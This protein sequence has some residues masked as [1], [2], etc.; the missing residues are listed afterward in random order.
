MNVVLV[1]PHFPPDHIGGVEQYS[2]RLAEDLRRHGDAPH[3]VC[4]E[5]I[6]EGASVSSQVDGTYGYPVHRVYVGRELLD[7]PVS[8]VYDVPGVESII[9]GVLDS[10]RADV[11]H[12]HS[13]Y[14][15]G[16]S[17][18][19]A[20]RRLEVPT[21]VTLHDFWF[22]CS[23]ITIIHPVGM[24]CPGPESAVKCA[25][26]LG[27]LRRRYRLPERLTGRR[28]GRLIEGLARAP[29]LRDVVSRLDVV[30]AVR[31]RQTRLLELLSQADVILSPSRFVRDR[32]AEAGLEPARVLLSRYG[33]EPRQS[34]QAGRADDAPLRIGYLGQLAPHKGVHVLIDAVRRL[35]GSPLTLHVHG[36][37]RPH[38]AYVERL[39]KAALGDSRI[40]FEG[41][42]PH[43]RVYDIL[44][45]LDV[46]VVPSVW[47]ENSPFV[48]QEAQSAH[49]PV[50][51]S[52]L[53]G[54]Q[55]LVADERDGL[56]FAAGDAHDLSRQLQRVVRTP[57]LLRQLR[58]DGSSVRQAD[59]ELRELRGHYARV[60]SARHKGRDAQ[61]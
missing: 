48:I 4:L 47:Y 21:V 5:A 19:A 14:L 58:P 17:A 40:H 30:E 34:N 8:S 35:Q 29:V 23:L 42:Y 33:I 57:G 3:V 11:V 49:V 37:P 32:I 50:L 59:D 41:P 10:S 1:T 7:A 6:H 61:T 9:A 56:L 25:W 60:A 31:M 18:L 27:T 28:A 13:G 43:D 46:I 26:C 53:G 45:G 51:A 38:P 20:A 55:E 39:H 52:R 36:D 44:S 54:M 12:V 24:P 16:A 2:G 15:L 22:V